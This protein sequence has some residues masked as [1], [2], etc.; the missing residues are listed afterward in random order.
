LTFITDKPP[1]LRRSRFPIAV[2][3]EEVGQSLAEVVHGDAVWA[4]HAPDNPMV[5]ADR[6]QLFRVLSNLGRNAL[7]AG[8]T[9]VEVSARS[10]GERIIIDVAD[11][12]P[13]LPPRARERLFQ[14]FSGSARPGSS[15]LGLAIAR[16]LMR[17]HGGDIRLV[18]S[19]GEG[20]T[21]EL[22]LP[23]VGSQKTEV[24]NEKSDALAE[25]V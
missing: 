21:F 17:A 10:T 12:G 18:R 14:P 16:E 1:E 13:G 9:R 23:E 7:Q 24:R 4:V 20:S 5:D 3:A 15:G 6:D 2:L 11:N 19:T 25:T 8:A 22:E